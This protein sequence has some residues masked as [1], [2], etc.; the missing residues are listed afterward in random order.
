[1]T[2]FPFGNPCAPRHLLFG[3]ERG[4]DVLQVESGRIIGDVAYGHIGVEKGQGFFFL[5]LLLV[6]EVEGLP[7]GS[8]GEQFLLCFKIVQNGLSLHGI[9]NKAF[10]VA[11]RGED[12]SREDRRPKR[13][14]FHCV[15]CKV[16]EN[17]QGKSVRG[18]K[19]V[20]FHVFSDG[21]AVRTV[22]SS[23]GHERCL[24]EISVFLSL[25]VKGVPC[26]SIT[27]G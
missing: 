7:E 14:P 22:V 12:R 26:C 25:K 10:G 4:A 16:I 20:E 3:L 27:F 18:K 13:V 5:C 17:R 8:F 11:A 9:R 24:T 23:N 21:R 19:T 6:D 1:M 2:E 15:F